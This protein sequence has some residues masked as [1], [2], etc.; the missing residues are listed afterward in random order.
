[1]LPWLAIATAMQAIPGIAG[2]FK[3]R[4][5]APGLPAY[6]ELLTPEQE[7]AMIDMWTKDV[8]Q[9][10]SKGT[11]RIKTGL[12]TRGVFRSGATQKAVGELEGAG[13]EALAKQLMDWNISKSQRKQNWQMGIAGMQENRYQNELNDWAGGMNAAGSSL[14]ES[15]SMIPW[16]TE[17]Y[18]GG[19]NKA[20]KWTGGLGIKPRAPKSWD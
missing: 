12:A 1:M 9:Q 7:R 6:E 20:P 14:G 3:K 16:L 8:G 17:L 11:T 4:P 15:L 18:A 10:V 5:K 19:R 2:M 13:N